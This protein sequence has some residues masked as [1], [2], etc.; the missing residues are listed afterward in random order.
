[1]PS[2][3]FLKIE[4]VCDECFSIRSL[5]PR[6]LRLCIIYYM[7]CLSGLAFKH[8]ISSVN[9]LL[10]QNVCCQEV[11]SM[12]IEEPTP[13]HPATFGMK[14]Q[15]CNLE[16]LILADISSVD[17]LLNVRIHSNHTLVQISVLLHQDLRI[18]G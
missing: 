10:K 5:R 2:V 12:E 13:V 1:M 14:L 18:P 17:C 16:R 6:L 8:G 11:I 15:M 9:C 7:T 4:D 3:T